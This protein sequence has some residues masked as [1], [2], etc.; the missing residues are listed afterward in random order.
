MTTDAT[1][2]AGLQSVCVFC[3]SRDGDDPAYTDAARDFGRLLAEH[4]L[5]LVYG[6]GGAG[7]MGAVADGALA[8]GGHVTG[9]IPLSMVYA[10][11]EHPG[12]VERGEM[13]HVSTM[14][15]R[16]SIMHERSGAFVALP[17]GVGTF[18]EVFEAIAWDQ[19]DLHDKPIGF[20]NTN[21][22]YAPLRRFV[23]SAH[24]AGF[25]PESTMD[26]LVFGDEPAELLE[27]LRARADLERTPRLGLDWSAGQP[28]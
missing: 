19:L 20:L 28:H 24:R 26:V 11:R 9:V 12:V 27:K 21:S 2:P 4:R 15:E 6:G 23:E 10:E 16:K 13:I 7:M 5:G 25:I 8:S 18:E 22:F 1:H 17:G 3:G 14:H